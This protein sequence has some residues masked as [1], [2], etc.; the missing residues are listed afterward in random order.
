MKNNRYV[1][2]MT[3]HDNELWTEKI[4][5]SEEEALRYLFEGMKE[6]HIEDALATLKRIQDGKLKVVKAELIVKRG[7]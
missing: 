7:L 6:Y 1:I 2:V 4:F 3:D 5:F